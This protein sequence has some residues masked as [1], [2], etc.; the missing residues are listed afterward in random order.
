MILVDYD[1]YSC[2]YGGDLV[3]RAVFERFARRAATLLQGM[4]LYSELVEKTEQEKV[5]LLLCEI[6]DRL[7]REDSRCGISRESIDGYDV[8]Y[9][10][11][12]GICSIR[13]LVRHSLGS[14]GVLYRGRRL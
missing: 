10:D 11:S 12:E 2:V 7:Y 5:K 1:F 3:P 6:C 14:E 9:S 8:S 13:Q 4:I